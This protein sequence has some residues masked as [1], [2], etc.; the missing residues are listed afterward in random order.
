MLTVRL[1]A[2]HD[3]RRGIRAACALLPGIVPLGVALGVALG[4]T[5]SSRL[6]AWLSAPLLVAPSPKLTPVT[7]SSPRSCA[8]SER[9][10]AISRAV[11][12]PRRPSMPASGQ[13]SAANA[14]RVRRPRRRGGRPPW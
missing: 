11:G 12:M 6:L 2:D 7:R 9:P 14:P 1:Q 13:T 3:V 10:L 5:T 4:D 8:D